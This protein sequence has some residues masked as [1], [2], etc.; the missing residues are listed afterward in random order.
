MKQPLL[1]NLMARFGTIVGRVYKGLMQPKTRI[2]KDRSAV[3]SKPPVS[4]FGE[5]ERIEEAKFHT[6][7]TEEGVPLEPGDLPDSYGET[8]VVL[9]P[10][11][12][13]LVHAYWEVTPE[14]IREARGRFGQADQRSQARL[15]FYD[16]SG[17]ASE[18]TTRSYFDVDIQLQARNWY[19]HL[20]NP[21][22]SY[23]AELGFATDSGVFFC[24][25]R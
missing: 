25:W 20:Q 11:D 6:P 7:G 24:V 14:K 3:A 15:R 23:F 18:G 2:T 5:Y 4:F 13:Y 16:I 8:R 22:R 1:V 10:V 12:P 17:V 21:Q 9:V 19:V